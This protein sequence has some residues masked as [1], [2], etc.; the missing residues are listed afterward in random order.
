MS[1]IKTVQKDWTTTFLLAFCLPGVERFYLGC[2]MSGILKCITCS[3]FGFW[4]W[5][6]LFRLAGG[7]ALCSNLHGKLQYIN[8]P[9][10]TH[11]MSS[12]NNVSKGGGNNNM[13]N[14]SDAQN[15]YFYM[16]FCSLLG[17]IFFYYVL[18]PIFQ[19]P[20]ETEEE[21]APVMITNN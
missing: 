10:S 1:S 13:T 5:I 2:P 17:L 6:D 14:T 15:D 16:I 8:G 21:E 19:S 12:N 20:I 4:Y 7:S 3:G 11:T 9:P 18:L